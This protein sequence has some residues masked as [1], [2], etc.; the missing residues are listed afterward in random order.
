MLPLT[1]N[2]GSGT[3]RRRRSGGMGTFIAELK[4]VPGFTNFDGLDAHVKAI[5]LPGVVWEQ[6]PAGRG[7]DAFAGSATMSFRL[8]ATKEGSFAAQDAL[9]NVPGV[10]DADVRRVM[11]VK[12]RARPTSSTESLPSSDLASAVPEPISNAT[13]SNSTACGLNIAVPSLAAPKGAPAARGRT[14]RRSVG[15]AVTSRARASDPSAPAHLAAPDRRKTRREERRER[16]ALIER[17][18]D[19]LRRREERIALL[20]R[21]ISR[22]KVRLEGQ[23]S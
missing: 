10:D 15:H 16:R 6:A 19:L 14:R 1:S 20:R 11:S 8:S 3:S 22:P 4:L 21:R 5:S 18:A 7:R 23:K 17:L 9:E 13:E 12:V 2:S